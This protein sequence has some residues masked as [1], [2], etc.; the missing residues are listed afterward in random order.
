MTGS[1]L[2]SILAALILGAA[3]LAAPL[4]KYGMT[5]LSY[6]DEM[7]KAA[8]LHEKAAAL[9]LAEKQKRGIIPDEADHLMIGLMGEA[10]TAITTT[11]AGVHEKRTSQLP[12]F[13]AL[14]VKYFTQAGLKKGD[15]V[16]ANFSGSYPGLNLA[17]LCAAEVMGLDIRYSV[18]VGSSSYGANCPAYTFPEMLE[19]LHEAGL[20]S[21]MPGL[22]T[23]G[24]GGDMGRN[25]AG[26]V[27]EEPEEIENMIK[28]LKEA[29]MGP[30]SI[31][32]FAQDI[33]LHEELYGD[34]KLFINAGGNSLGLGAGED[35]PLL[36]MGAGL[37]EPQKLRIT[38]RSGLVERYLD[39]GIPAVHLLDVKSLCREG[40][41]FDPLV[42]PRIGTA[43]LYFTKP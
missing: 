9:I 31:E 26:Y 10:Y 42:R 23:L 30:A 29:G 15:P 38:P 16:G 6:A 34:I 22:V 24:G 14:C 5:R 17:A 40:I 20:L 8:L 19:T 7:E 35:S 28:R 13:A 18:S 11:T 3:L 25:M 37:L 32:S 1:F 33:A 43:P 12:D 27:L 36:S 39:K 2:K 41:S 4:G 21:R